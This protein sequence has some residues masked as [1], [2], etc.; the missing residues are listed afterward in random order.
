MTHETEIHNASCYSVSA[1]RTGRLAFPGLSNHSG[2]EGLLGESRCRSDPGAWARLFITQREEAGQG[3]AKWLNLEQTEGTELRWCVSI[4][5]CRWTG[6][7][8]KATPPALDFV[9]KLG[10]A[11][12]PKSEL[13]F[14][15]IQHIPFLEST[16]EQ[17]IARQRIPRYI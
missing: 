16:Q 4:S 13:P 9:L 14:L 17:R 5:C 6:T 11:Q 2:E 10:I 1:R 8:G 12:F 7:G 3:E 15:L